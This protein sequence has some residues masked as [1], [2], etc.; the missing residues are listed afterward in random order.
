M[1]PRP[2]SKHRGRGGLSRR[3]FMKRSG[4]ATLAAVAAPAIIPASAL[5]LDGHVAPSNR[6]V[7]AAI[8]VGGQ[9]SHNM[10]ALTSQPDTQMVAVCDVDTTHLA[11]AK[12]WVEEYYANAN[13]AD[14]KGCET[15]NDFREVI[16]RDDID[17]VTVCTP[18]F[19]HAVISVAAAKAGKDM[20]CE[21]PLANT[22]QEGRAVVDAVNRY[23][24]VLQTGSHERS[25]ENAR[26]AAELVRNG[27]IGKL[28]EI[29]CN[30]PV[31]HD[32]VGLQPPMPVPD[33]LD[34]DMWL[35]PCPHEP[36]TEKR[37][38][39]YFRYILDYS[40]GEMTD[41]GAHVMDLAQLGHN[42]D[43][44]GPQTI[45]GQGRFLKNSLFNT[46]VEYNLTYTFAD[47]VPMYTRSVG[48]RGVK[49]VG[50]D[51]WVFIHVHGGNLEASHPSLLK[52]VVGPDE[53][54][55]GRSPG[56]HRD[57]LNNV[58]SRGKPMA[59]AEV[60]HR[61]GSLCHLGNI[62]MLLGRKIQWDP[63]KE[64]VLNDDEANRMLARPPR[65]PWSLV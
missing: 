41:R 48:P 44:T 59:P 47:G 65:G 20:Y 37:C 21:K 62:A 50:T 58:K 34:Y 25:R 24:R 14:Y 53:E 57:F 29:H 40:G 9:G 61:S 51:G 3:Q 8:G 43:H 7:M 17:A 23:G 64:V 5:G 36:Y 2:E 39:F 22:V 4:A 27:R 49:F 16:A 26:Y 12:Q 15:Y 19:W 55:L 54:Q 30:M 1:K 13:D 11:A 28:K 60:G 18:D 45:E 63:E 6:I 56:H 42:T 52:E 38:H 46:A 10:R 31:D 33:T 35:G 32:D